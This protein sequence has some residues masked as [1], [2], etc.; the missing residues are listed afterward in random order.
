MR[1]P[2][3]H[4][5]GATGARLNEPENSWSPYTAEPDSSFTQSDRDSPRIVLVGEIFISREVDG[6]QANQP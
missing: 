2:P 1:S 4:S 3:P 6:D 5:R